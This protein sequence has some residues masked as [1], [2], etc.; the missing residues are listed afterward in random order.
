MF[1]CTTCGLFFCWA[2]RTT[3]PEDKATVHFQTQGASASGG[4]L[5]F[6]TVTSSTE[7]VTLTKEAAAHVK[8]MLDAIKDVI[9]RA[10]GESVPDPLFTGAVPV[11]GGGDCLF[12]ALALIFNTDMPVMRGTLSRVYSSLPNDQWQVLL[13][14][15]LVETDRRREPWWKSWRRSTTYG[16]T[17]AAALAEFKRAFVKGVAAPG[18]FWGDYNTIELAAKHFDCGVQIIQDNQRIITTVN[19]RDAAEIA[20][21]KFDCTSKHYAP[22]KS[23]LHPKQFRVSRASVSPALS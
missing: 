21:L 1:Y 22:V 9:I 5:L 19:Y 18:D 11:P 15:E 23:N 7:S 16:K 20:A 4:C 2:C 14:T 17:T 3:L 8:G 10:S 13:E 6:P 12:E